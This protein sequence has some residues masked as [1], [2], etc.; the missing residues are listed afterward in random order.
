MKQDSMFYVMEPSPVIMNWPKSHPMSKKKVQH[1]ENF[2]SKGG[3]LVNLPKITSHVTS[4][5]ENK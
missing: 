5:L 4:K 3:T 1:G 2:K